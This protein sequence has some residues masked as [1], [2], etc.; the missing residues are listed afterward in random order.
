[1]RLA[2]EETLDVGVQ[3]AARRAG[4]SADIRK[5]IG[6]LARVHG[7][8]AQRYVAS[9]EEF[10]E[11]TGRAPDHTMLGFASKGGRLQIT[12]SFVS[13]TATEGLSRAS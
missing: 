10:H 6:W 8:D 7:L 4:S 12:A 13:A 9:I 3:F 11:M 2:G 1:M 5:R